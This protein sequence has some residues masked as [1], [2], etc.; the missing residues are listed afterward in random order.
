M[1]SPGASSWLADRN[2]TVKFLVLLAVSAVLL[3][4][5]DP[6]TP[7]LLYVLALAGVLAAGRIPWRRLLAAHTP[8]ALFG[9]SLLTVNAVTRPGRLAWQWGWLDVTQEGL[10]VGGSLAIRTLVIGVCA[11]G[12]VLTTDGTRL[13]VSFHQQLRLGP[14]LTYAILAGYR[15]LEQLP[16]EWQ[17]IRMAQAIRS[18]ST[19]HEALPRSPRALGRAA[20]ALLVTAIRRGERMS[21]ALETRGLGDGPR[22]IHRPVPLD[23]RDASL[24]AGVLG[25]V[26]ATLAVGALAGWLQGPSA[27]GVF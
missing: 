14:R 9:F 2:P 4:V 23:R 3:G 19:R 24:A 8:F 11:I 17:T 6:W 22:T 16:A 18:G 13:M 27:L 10:L 1:T 15:L 5:F 12:F 26:A 20:F 21:I 7:A 25:V